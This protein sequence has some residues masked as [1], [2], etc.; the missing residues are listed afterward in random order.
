[1]GMHTINYSGLGRRAAPALLAAAFIFA[2]AASLGAQDAPAPGS[3]DEM[4]GQ[5]ETVT[6]AATTSKEAEGA[7]GFLK[8]D[9]V[10]VGGSVTGK[11]G[12]N[13]VWSPAWDGSS[14][15]LDPTRYYL[16]P[17]LEG[18][19]TLVAKPLVDFGVNMEFRTSWPFST[20]G[21]YLT[22][23]TGTSTSVATTSSNATIPN[24]SI[25][26]LYSKFNWQDRV[27]FSFGKQPISWGVAKGAFQPADDIFA[28]NSTIDLTNTSAEREGPISLKTTIPLGVTNNL[29]FYAGLPTSSSSSSSLADSATGSTST[30]SVDPADARLAVKGEYGFGNTE[31]GLGAYYSYNDHPRALLMATTSLGTW[32]IFGEG[33]LKYGSERYFVTKTTPSPANQMTGLVGVQAAD[34]LY[35]TGTAGGYYMNSDTNW[36]VYLAYLYNGEAQKNVDF[37]DAYTYYFFGHSSQIDKS[38]YGTHYAFASISKSNLFHDALGQDKLSA[39]VIAISDLTDLSGYVMPSV[40]W[41]FFDYISIQVGATFNF[42]AAGSEY[43]VYGVG[44]NSISS[45]PGAA[46]NL[47]LTVGTGNF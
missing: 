1:M 38:K 7:S 37:Q 45:K 30:V 16:S 21:S 12:F 28:L 4:F 9:Q 5:A 15:L 22:S 24:I 42:G 43:I 36:T 17:D 35:F 18:K 44:N 3:D 6:P 19:V 20:T 11:L 41:A 33:V 31:L 2:C 8:Y 29:Y 25:W 14:K 32:N 46:L 40:T 39:Q 27:Y 34:Q 13:S 47:L 26:S 10:K 23:A